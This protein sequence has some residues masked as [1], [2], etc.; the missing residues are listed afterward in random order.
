MVVGSYPPLPGP[1]TAATLAA[2]Q[3]A[4]DE[5][6]EVRMVG[7][8][9]G[10]APLS[11]PIVGVLAGRR[12]EQARRH[13][14]CPAQLTLCLQPGVPFSDV[15]VSKQLVT[16]AAL[17]AV[18]RRFA[19]VTVVV[20]GDLS[21]P[22]ASVWLLCR[23]VD[24]WSVADETA[25]LELS[26]RCRVPRSSIS[27]DPVR[28]YPVVGGPGLYEPGKEAGLTLVEIPAGSAFDRARARARS[29]ATLV[30]RRVLARGR[31][32]LGR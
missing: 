11:V 13:L 7:Y 24:R 23:G 21:L 27:V 18:M 9:T 6:C 8:R 28:P 20:T 10:A 4:W 26:K 12:L 19:S 17:A 3:R 25:A 30:A 5:G 2:V 1:A 29:M 32:A 22:R 15:Q 16:A 14:A 31:A